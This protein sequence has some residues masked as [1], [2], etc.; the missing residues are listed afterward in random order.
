MMMKEAEFPKK[1]YQPPQARG[2]A[3]SGEVNFMSSDGF[4]DEIGAPSFEDEDW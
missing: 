1:T 2:I 3:M 4:S